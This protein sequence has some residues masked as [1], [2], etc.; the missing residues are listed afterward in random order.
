M[1]EGE[2]DTQ[3]YLAFLERVWRSRG[4]SDA[5]VRA[6]LEKVEGE[7]RASIRS[8]YLLYLMHILEKLGVKDTF[9]E[10]RKFRN[11]SQE[12]LDSEITKQL[13]ALQQQKKGK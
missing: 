5:Q 6:V 3:A 13:Q 7:K 11:A 2:R 9:K 12:E 10:A 1:A 4:V 8:G